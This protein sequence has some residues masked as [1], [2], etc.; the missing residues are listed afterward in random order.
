MIQFFEKA[1]W[2]SRLIIIVPVI[3]SI[4]AAVVL[5]L[6]GSYKMFSVVYE[7]GI[8][9]ADPHSFK[10]VYKDIISNIITSVDVFLIAT[11]LIIFA[12]GLYELFISKIDVAENDKKSSKILIIHSLDEL[13]DRLANVIIMVLIVTFF[14]A[15]FTFKYDSIASLAMLAGGILLIA[16]TSYIMHLGHKNDSS[17]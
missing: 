1:L 15:A 2:W 16:L 10:S 4:I 12:L 9:V 17:H 14:N 8:I 7:I 13:K 6:L 11:V 3:S 5:I